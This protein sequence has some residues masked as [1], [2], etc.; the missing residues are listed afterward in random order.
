MIAI[1]KNLRF[2]GVDMA[3]LPFSIPV[4]RQSDDTTAGNVRCVDL[5]FR[6]VVSSVRVKVET[7]E[8]QATP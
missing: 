7:S 3:G 2:V 6:G 5:T 1:C 4:S 8:E